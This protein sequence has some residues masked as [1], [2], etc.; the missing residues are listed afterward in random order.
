MS[1]KQKPTKVEP[2]WDNG[3][4]SIIKETYE[5]P[6]GEFYRVMA[7]SDYNEVVVPENTAKRIV[8]ML[9]NINETNAYIDNK[10][11]ALLSQVQEVQQESTD[12]VPAS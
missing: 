2:L 9:D 3:K 11:S 7:K 1:D 8:A 10:A 6:V 4:R 12:L 5:T